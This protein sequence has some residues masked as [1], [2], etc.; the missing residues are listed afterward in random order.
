VKGISAQVV[1]VRSVRI[2]VKA[3]NGEEIPAVLRNVLYVPELSRRA[4][5]SYYRLFT[6]TQAREQRHC[7]VLHDPVDHLR[8]HTAHG[9]GRDG[10]FGACISY[11]VAASAD[12]FSDGCYNFSRDNAIGQ[13][14]VAFKT[15]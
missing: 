5:W 4:S 11:G 14:A 3:E 6:L 7:V 9:G 10:S 1:G 8:L 13:A 15:R 2:I 12:C